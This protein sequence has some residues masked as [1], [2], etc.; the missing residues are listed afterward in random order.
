MFGLMLLLDNLVFLVQLNPSRD[1][2]I[3]PGIEI[4]LILIKLLKSVK[5]T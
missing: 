3:Q 1:K 5:L 4:K 2:G